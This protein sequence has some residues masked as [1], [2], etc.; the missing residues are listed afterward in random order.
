MEEDYVATTQ[1]L[2]ANL[3]KKPKL[4]EKYL[5]KPP[6]RFIHDIISNTM[7]ATGFPE[8]LYHGPELN[9][10]GIKEKQAKISWLSKLIE[11]LESVTS[12]SIAVDPNKIVAGMEPER[13]NRMLQTFASI[14]T[15]VANG[16]LTMP[17]ILENLRSEPRHSQ[18]TKAQQPSETAAAP[19]QSSPTDQTQKQGAAAAS[20][21]KDNAESK[22]Q[23]LL[24]TQR[25]LGALI[26]RPR[27]LDKL[28]RRPPFRFLFDVIQS[29]IAATGFP[30]QFLDSTV[31]ID[32]A[33]I[34]D[35]KFKF[36]FLSKL[37]VIA[38][39][40][41]NEDLCWVDPKQ[42]IAG[43]NP[44]GTNIVL[45]RLAEAATRSLDVDA[46]KQRIAAI[47]QQQRAKKEE[48]KKERARKEHR[49]QSKAAPKREGQSRSTQRDGDREAVPSGGTNTARKSAPK[50]PKL[51]L[52]Q[53]QKGSVQ[54]M[55]SKAA[56]SKPMKSEDVE[57]RT[58]SNAIKPVAINMAEIQA[59]PDEQPPRFQPIQKLQ[60]PRTARRAPPKLKSNVVDEDKG[61]DL[62]NAVIIMD[63]ADGDGQDDDGD[64][65]A[66]LEQI[67]ESKEDSELQRLGFVEPLDVDR[68]RAG[69]EPVG[70]GLDGDHG[71]LVRDILD[72]QNQSGIKL[73]HTKLGTHRKDSAQSVERM[74][75][76]RQMIQTLCQLCL[77]LGKCID[78][79]FQDVDA[80]GS[81]MARWKQ[82]IA[83][84][85][86]KLAVERER[87]QK[88]LTPLHRRLHEV[89]ESIRRQNQLIMEKKAV[90]LR[91]EA[92]AADVIRKRLLNE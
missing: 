25:T 53:L 5:R 47:A 40:V 78:L 73:D 11:C 49:E 28:L 75:S 57:S 1:R 21:T 58:A 14:A 67:K 76:L 92:K 61:A 90:L 85:Q 56:A 17:Q 89:E 20:T 45:T 42:I 8:G 91:N 30:L 26:E 59:P 63:D 31:D 62:K 77:P 64:H 68:Q 87:T 2:F 38:S 51:E 54:P 44:E 71:K 34:K 6:F 33:D 16:E 32:R 69:A 29:L 23:W 88:V 83:A 84:N 3:I 74:E 41:S 65:A 19:T 9:G 79:V 35:T 82:L 70:D 81:E 18:Q 46:V 12:E 43:R 4:Q 50:M 36:Y 86:S 60:R 39:A 22:E 37:I 27:L 66:D 10:K 7:K 72:A 52:E 55:S 80:I 15:D 24:D 48:Q 13:T